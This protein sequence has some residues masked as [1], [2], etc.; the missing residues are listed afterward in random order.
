MY[1]LTGGKIRKVEAATLS[2]VTMSG[3]RTFATNRKSN[4]WIAPIRDLNQ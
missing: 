3:F 1:L 2:R 4:A